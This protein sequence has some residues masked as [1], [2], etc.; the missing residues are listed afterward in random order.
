MGIK[1]LLEEGESNLNQSIYC[2]YNRYTSRSFNICIVRDSFM[3][4]CLHLLAL[5]AALL[6]YCYSNPLGVFFRSLNLYL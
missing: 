1:K 4:L 2:C 5:L 6:R 3:S